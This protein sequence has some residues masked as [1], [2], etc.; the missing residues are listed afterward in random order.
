MEI[1]LVF[2]SLLEDQYSGYYE[3]ESG[4]RETRGWHQVQGG[5]VLCSPERLTGGDG[6]PGSSGTPC[7]PLA[8]AFLGAGAQ[9][10]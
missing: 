1:I 8:G 6:K 10:S 3:D 2:S 5:G 7:S 9:P 4:A